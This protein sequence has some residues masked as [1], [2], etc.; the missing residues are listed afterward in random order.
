MMCPQFES[1]FIEIGSTICSSDSSK[2]DSN[3]QL[4]PKLIA[5]SQKLLNSKDFYGEI[6]GQMDVENYLGN[7]CSVL[8]D[9]EETELEKILIRCPIFRSFFTFNF[10]E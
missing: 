10:T 5:R 4:L 3:F 6:R 2:N 9:V 1:N 7:Y 8:I